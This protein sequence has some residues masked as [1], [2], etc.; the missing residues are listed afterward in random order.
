MNIPNTLTMSRIGLAGILL[1]LLSVQVQFGKSVAL[2]VFVLASITDYLDGHLAR[3]VYGVTD[4]GK[5][6]DPL[7]DKILTCVAFVC[8]VGIRLPNYPQVSL[9]PAW[10]AVVI[11]TREFMVTG[12][13]LLAT[14]KGQVLA[15]GQWG[16]HK[17]VWQIVAIVVILLGLAIRQDIL[18]DLSA[19]ALMKYDF[20]MHWLV[21][22]IGVAV[23]LI[24]VISGSLYFVQN[25]DLI[26][27]GA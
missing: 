6:M 24:T 1:L 8:F 20:L 16:K 11:I 27:R 23:A 7:A 15:A 25:M 10:I 2:V 14:G 19:D 26:R 12:L 5:L 4:F 3:N 18:H 13:R 22:A 9:L 21:L 17:T